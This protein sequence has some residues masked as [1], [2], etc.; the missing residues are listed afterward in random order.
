MTLKSCFDRKGSKKFL[1]DKEKAMAFLELPDD[2]PGSFLFLEKK[3]YVE[4]I[5]SIKVKINVS[6]PPKINHK[7]LILI[8][9]LNE[10]SSTMI[11][12]AAT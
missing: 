1:S 10:N 7:Y 3:I 6:I 2:I 8:F 11:S 4:I 5:Y 9:L 12:E